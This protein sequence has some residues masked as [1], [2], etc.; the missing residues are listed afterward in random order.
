VWEDLRRARS[1]PGHA[2]AR[3]ARRILSR[4]HHR[5][6][7]E[8]VE[9]RSAEE[10]EARLAAWRNAALAADPESDPIADLVDGALDPLGGGEGILVLEP[11]GARM[12]L[13]RASALVE[14]LTPAPYG[15]LYVAHGRREALV[16][17][18]VGPP[19]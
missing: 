13:S 5:A 1:A 15:R 12:P 7:P 4:E 2:G 17:A 10:V 19:R 3:A 16:A 11:T 8:R 6:L 14:R 18:G 9:G